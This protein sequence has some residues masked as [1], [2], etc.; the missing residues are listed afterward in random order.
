M[1]ITVLE[2]TYSIYQF[3]INS[4]L[5]EWIYKSEFYSVTRTNEE[6]SVVT[7]QTNISE[8]IRCSR[9]WR[10]LKVAGPLALSLT[11]IIARISD[12]LKEKDIPIFTISTYNTDYILLGEKDLSAG[13]KALQ[14]NGYNISR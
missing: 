13:V 1:T 4:E 3:D 8:N 6:I 10:I 2:N 11:G 12:V 5:P 14:D 9:D 7:I